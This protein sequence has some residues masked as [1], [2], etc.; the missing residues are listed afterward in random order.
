[1]IVEVDE[2]GTFDLDRDFLEEYRDQ[3]VNWGYGAMSWVT[4]K[5]TYSRDGEDWWQTCQRVIEGMFTIQRVHCLKRNLPWDT[6]KA[7]RFAQKA[8][9]RLFNFKWTPPGRGLWMMGTDYIYER[10]GAA[11]NNCGFVSTKEINRDFAAPFKWMFS[12]SML[13]VGVG[14][15]TRGAGRGRIVVQGAPHELPARAPGAHFGE[16]EAVE[17]VGPVASVQQHPR[18]AQDAQVPGDPGLGH[19]Q[20]LRELVHGELLPLEQEEDPDAGRI[21][22]GLEDLLQRLGPGRGHGWVRSVHQDGRIIPT[23]RLVARRGRPGAPQR[24]RT[25]G[26]P[27]VPRSASWPPPFGRIP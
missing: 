17:D 11:M 18:L 8:Y 7:Q 25:R 14:F 15:D 22:E 23:F 4:Y 26:A 6:D 9:D 3:P 5:R 24:E 12:M 2:Y 16:R 27:R 13:G 20:H 10:G 19:P 21:R 1:M